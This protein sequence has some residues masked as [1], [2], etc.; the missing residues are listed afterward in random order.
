MSSYLITDGARMHAASRGEPG[1]C[2]CFAEDMHL[3]FD[4]RVPPVPT[5]AEVRVSCGSCGLPVSM[6]VEPLPE[7]GGPAAGEE[8]IVVAP[9]AG[10]SCALCA[11]TEYVPTVVTMHNG[12]PGTR[13]DP[14]P[15]CASH[16]PDPER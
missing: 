10:Q 5:G 13:L 15:A 8:V 1:T 16:T 3:V 2:Q 4:V 12:R 7:D 11:G 14:C 6:S 9:A